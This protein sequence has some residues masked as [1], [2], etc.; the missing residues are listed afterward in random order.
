MKIALVP[1]HESPGDT[2]ANLG[3]L[4]GWVDRLHERV[5]MILF[6][7]I[8]MSAPMAWTS[9]SG[10]AASIQSYE[11]ED[12]FCAFAAR[13]RI[14]LATE[15][16][17]RTLG[18]PYRKIL[19][20]SRA[21]QLDAQSC[22]LEPDEEQAPNDAPALL[23]T[24]KI[25]DCQVGLVSH[26]NID[27]DRIVDGAALAR[28]QVLLV[29]LRLAGSDDELRRIAIHNPPRALPPL[30][31]R[32]AEVARLTKC[33]VLAVNAVGEDTDTQCGPCGGAFVFRPDGSAEVSQ[34]VF[35]ESVVEFE[36]T[37]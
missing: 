5:D 15:L 7:Q 32:L 10:A 21:G 36:I 30:I 14:P 25:K 2:R 16:L 1:M 33:Y 9:E 18:K 12:M 4:A 26:A 29:P 31:E 34:R 19:L 13:R 28:S 8:E 6:P 23:V 11:M 3:T 20:A 27:S 22:F 37:Y 17:D 24:A 35:D